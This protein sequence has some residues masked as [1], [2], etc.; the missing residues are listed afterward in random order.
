V[1]VAAAVFAAA[2]FASLSVV[3]VI[4]VF[5]RASIFLPEHNKIVAFNVRDHPTK[6]FM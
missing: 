1:S 3:E 6:L 4:C 2:V 5:V